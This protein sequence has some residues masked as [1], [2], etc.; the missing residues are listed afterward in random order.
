M[1]LLYPCQD[2]SSN[3]KNLDIRLKKYALQDGDIFI[4]IKHFR[5]HILSRGFCAVS[6]KDSLKMM[7]F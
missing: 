7:F 4:D 1:E 5:L 6:H 3:S 2:A